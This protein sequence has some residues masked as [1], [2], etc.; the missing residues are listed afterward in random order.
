VP[1]G[2]RALLFV[3]PVHASLCRRYLRIMKAGCDE[4]G[5]ERHDS[6]HAHHHVA[7]G[8]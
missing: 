5:G 8:V 1:E 2:F 7:R 3:A 6:C 4:F